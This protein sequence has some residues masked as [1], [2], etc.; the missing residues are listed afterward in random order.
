MRMNV[1]TNLLLPKDLVAEVDRH[2]GRRGR[3]R[4]VADALRERL[5]RDRLQDAVRSTAGVLSAED[6][7]HWATSEL[8]QAWV[9]ERRDEV[10]DAGPDEA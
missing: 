8:V 10:T 1:R 6:Y 3:S 5:R 9:R 2:A 7:P 4:Y